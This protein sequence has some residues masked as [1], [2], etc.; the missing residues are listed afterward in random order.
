MASQAAAEY[1]GLVAQ[2]AAV[3]VGNAAV[4]TYHFFSTPAGLL[5]ALIIVVLLAATVGRRRRL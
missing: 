4:S 1:I 3:A 5:A 2:R